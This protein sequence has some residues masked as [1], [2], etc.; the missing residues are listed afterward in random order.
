MYNIKE[1]TV[2]VTNTASTKKEVWEMQSSSIVSPCADL[3][4]VW[5]AEGAQTSRAEWEAGVS[6]YYI[7][8]ALTDSDSVLH[9]SHWHLL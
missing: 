4:G 8:V 5:R 2:S 9:H 7:V 3:L 6:Q 1:H